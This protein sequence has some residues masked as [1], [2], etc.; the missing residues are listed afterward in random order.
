MLAEIHL[1]EEEKFQVLL[2]AFVLFLVALLVALCLAITCCPLNKWLL[3]LDEKRRKRRQELAVRRQRNLVHSH[4]ITSQSSYY[5]N[6]HSHHFH[7]NQHANHTNNNKCAAPQLAPNFIGPPPAYEAALRATRLQSL[8]SASL[9][10]SPDW[11]KTVLT[12]QSQEEPANERQLDLGDYFHSPKE[13]FFAPADLYQQ[14]QQVYGQRQNHL[15]IPMQQ[16]GQYWP[17]PAANAQKQANTSSR[18][19]APV[20]LR[21]WVKLLEPDELVQRAREQT[22]IHRKS[23]QEPP[24]RSMSRQLS[25][26]QLFGSLMTLAGAKSAAICDEDQVGGEHSFKVERESSNQSAQQQNQ[27]QHE[28]Q[29]SSLSGS[30]S[31]FTSGE[32]VVNDR[33]APIIKVEPTDQPQPAG[34][35][36]SGKPPTRES[37]VLV[38]STPRRNSM[39]TIR[40]ITS[41]VLHM[42][43][44]S[45]SYV[46]DENLISTKKHNQL[47]FHHFHAPQSKHVQTEVDESCKPRGGG[48]STSSKTKH[49]NKMCQLLVSICDIEN[50]LGSSCLEERA[51]LKLA[52]NSSIYVKCEILAPK[53]SSTKSA[54]SR[55]LRNPLRVL[56]HQESSVSHQGTHTI[57]FGPTIP[58][59]VIEP[60]PTPVAR[61]TS[62]SRAEQPALVPA[63]KQLQ[64][65][66]Q[67]TCLEPP[68]D[69]DQDP[70]SFSSTADDTDS[71]QQQLQQPQEAGSQRPRHVVNWR[72][73]PGA[74]GKSIVMFNSIPK[75]IA[76]Q[77]Q[78]AYSSVAATPQTTANTTNSNSLGSVAQSLDACY[79]MVGQ[80]IDLIQFDSVFVSPILSK[81]LLESGH[82]RLRVFA[83]CK[84]VNE[85]CLA[86]LKL[87]LK[88]LMRAQSR[89]NLG[90][91]QAST[92]AAGS[93]PQQQA[94][95]I[96]NNL[97]ANLVT[98]STGSP[99]ST[100][101][102]QISAEE[103]DTAADD[104]EQD[105]A[106]L[107]R[108][109]QRQLDLERATAAGAAAGSLGDHFRL[110]TT[111]LGSGSRL[112]PPTTAVIDP[113][114]IA[115]KAGDGQQLERSSSWHFGS[116]QPASQ[117]EQQQQLPPGMEEL[118]GQT[119]DNCNKLIEQNYR[120][121]MMV[122]HWLNYLVAPSYECQLVEES[123]G[124]LVLGLTY[125]PTSNRLVFNAHRASVEPNS[126]LLSWDHK[127]LV[128]RLRMQSD[129][130]Y[131]LRFMMVANNRVIKR[132]QTACS[133]KPEW[134]S[135]EPVT[136]D[137][138]NVNVE[139]P[140]FV[141]ALVMRNPHSL[142]AGSGFTLGGSLQSLTSYYQLRPCGPQGTA[143]GLP[144]EADTE[145][146]R[147]RRAPR[148]RP[149]LPG[150][151]Q[152]DPESL[153]LGCGGSGSNTG[154]I[155][156]PGLESSHQQACHEPRP[157]KAK[158]DLVVGHLV[159]ADELWHELRAQP[160]KQLVKQ[161]RLL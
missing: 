157:G 38:G 20:M 93:V 1:S 31:S 144:E 98:A 35:A 119:D 57:D 112:A 135:Q 23:C 149:P 77:Q 82:I 147:S 17:H 74:D 118:G 132:K 123:R 154:G 36:R 99:L 49:A 86:E 43:V 120:R 9:E 96:L 101:I 159:L 10:A 111:W 113:S 40:S 122:S 73:E 97:L 48:S 59:T 80:T 28:E 89:D 146:H 121:S 13:P 55:L 139:H 39:P 136:F 156:R 60:Y 69:S 88:Q 66:Q 8:T 105:Q 46:K 58:A 18:P 14:Q 107:A 94:D 138:V 79:P 85:T 26:P 150:A 155:Y 41:R 19:K 29:P 22:Q 32:D 83:Q 7:H 81:S 140:S 24:R 34:S 92:R 70:A 16:A 67:L 4:Q 50:L 54:A 76:Q 64:H 124:Q 63:D 56:T 142:A 130:T 108:L 106:E 137:L 153:R 62:P 2:V 125:L 161:L 68:A 151:C 117:M 42:N 100:L 141:V 104:A 47:N 11:L 51:C 115:A 33:R 5:T 71:G 27:H 134:D 53:A 44:A 90:D 84:Y 129:T 109:R 3:G 102:E 87:P 114:V 78:L 145:E 91:V 52:Q 15:A 116:E 21:L 72:H 61:A 131:L 65:Q 152:S 148:A 30:T 103:R 95:F 160:R 37:G 25:I 143:E 6:Y 12:N 126:N 75:Q 110:A 133:R 158:R 127:Q 128:K 45:F